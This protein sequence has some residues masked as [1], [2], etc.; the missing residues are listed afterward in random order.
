[1]GK[2]V[3]AANC[4]LAAAR[5]DASM[6]HNAHPLLREFLLTRMELEGGRDVEDLME[7]AWLSEV[8][9][10][11]LSPECVLLDDQAP[12][13]AVIVSQCTWHEFRGANPTRAETLRDSIRI[14]WELR[15]TELLNAR[16][17]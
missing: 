8:H 1:M 3:E 11:N 6:A 16:H 2:P 4:Y 5:M 13:D 15:A 10:F 12:S 17:E 9:R 7:I 14:A